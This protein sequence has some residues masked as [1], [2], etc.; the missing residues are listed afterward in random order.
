MLERCTPP[1]C[2]QSCCLGLRRMDLPPNS[3]Q[4]IWYLALLSDLLFI[5][6][7]WPGSLER[8]EHSQGDEAWQI[9]RRPDFSLQSQMSDWRESRGTR[10]REG[11]GRRWERVLGSGA[12]PKDLG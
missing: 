2:T 11:S 9:Q 8:P 4:A 5:M 1:P 10:Q 12:W 6:G 7:C 3:L